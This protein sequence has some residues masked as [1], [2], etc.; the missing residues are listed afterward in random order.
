M[1]YEKP[2]V[3][4]LHGSIAHG[5]YCSGGSNPTDDCKTGSG[6]AGGNCKSGYGADTRPGCAG[7]ASNAYCVTGYGADGTSNSNVC[8]TGYAAHDTGGA[9]CG[10]GTSAGTKGECK[11]GG[12]AGYNG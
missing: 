2:I 5:G 6:Y 12:S 9:G 1:K 8:N 11:T 3:I 4:S 10:G 7:G